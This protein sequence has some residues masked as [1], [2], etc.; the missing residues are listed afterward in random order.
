[1]LHM[2]VSRLDNVSQQKKSTIDKHKWNRAH[3][4]VT[5]VSRLFHIKVNPLTSTSEKQAQAQVT[6]VSRFP[7]PVKET[8]LQ[9]D[10][11]L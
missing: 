1:M 8:N 3:A 10:T 5:H 9:T 2:P 11:T 7:F 4:K 6:H